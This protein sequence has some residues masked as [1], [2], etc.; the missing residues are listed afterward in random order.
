MN[1]LEW[2]VKK[3]E[4]LILGSNLDTTPILDQLIVVAK[5]Y[6]NYLNNADQNYTK[7][8]TLYKNLPAELE[9]TS[10][11]T[12]ELIMAYE[13]DILRYV[14]DIKTMV[15]KADSVLK[16]EKWPSLRGVE[17][18]LGKLEKLTSAEMDEADE[19]D[20]V[21]WERIKLY[22]KNM[23][24]LKHLEKIWNEKLEAYENAEKRPQDDDED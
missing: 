9:P 23:D 5:N 4:R 18:K 15:D 14:Q 7:F 12:I 13:E 16:V 6:N 24:T 1:S 22:K 2:R 8:N 17:E 19:Q 11:S 20:Q 21:L 3:L 10:P